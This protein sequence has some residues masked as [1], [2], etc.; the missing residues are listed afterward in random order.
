MR[1]L[2]TY[3]KDK[4]SIQFFF[5][6]GNSLLVNSEGKVVEC[7]LMEVFPFVS[8][9]NQSLRGLFHSSLEVFQKHSDLHP[10]VDISQ[11]HISTSSVF[12][13]LVSISHPTVPWESF[14]SPIVL[15]ILPESIPF[16]FPT[17]ER[18]KGKT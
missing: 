7:E 14:L 18:V 13:E 8:K 1:V 5:G 17:V 4:E 15:Q 11:Y 3:L 12:H 9:R 6:N 2:E 16:A 10:V